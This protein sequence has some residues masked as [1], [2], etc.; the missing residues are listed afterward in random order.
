MEK[1]GEPDFS[2][3]SE[4]TKRYIWHFQGNA[5]GRIFD[6]DQASPLIVMFIFGDVPHVGDGTNSDAQLIADFK[7]LLQVMLVN[8]FSDDRG[9]QIRKNQRAEM[10][11]LYL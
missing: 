10:P 8:P 11:D 9:Q 3:Y 2:R 6:F 1:T 5:C 7:D 4:H